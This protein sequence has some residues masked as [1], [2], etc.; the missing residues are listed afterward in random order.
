[1]NLKY[2]KQRNYYRNGDIVYNEEK[3]I[4]R[5]GDSIVYGTVSDPSF[6][7]NESNGN[8]YYTSTTEG[9]ESYSKDRGVLTITVDPFI[10]LK[11]DVNTEMYLIAEAPNILEASFELDESNGNFIINV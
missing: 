9:G 2:N 3:R 4:R 5:S 10:Y 11:I 6:T 7:L 1:M 8:L